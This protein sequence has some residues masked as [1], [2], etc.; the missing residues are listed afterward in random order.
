MELILAR[1]ADRVLDGVRLDQL[2]LGVQRPR[3][4]A[5]KGEAD[6]RLVEEELVG[7]R[8]APAARGRW[9]EGAGGRGG[10][11]AA[12]LGVRRLLV[13][14]H[15]RRDRPVRREAP[16]PQLEVRLARPGVELGVSRRR[17]S[18]SRR[19][20]LAANTVGRRCATTTI[21][22]CGGGRG[23]ISRGVGWR[24]R[25]ANTARRFGGRR[26]LGDD[27]ASVCQRRRYLLLLLLLLLH[28]RRK[29]GVIELLDPNVEVLRVRHLPELVHEFDEEL[30]PLAGDR[31]H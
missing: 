7:E 23:A 14:R 26:R 4:D 6:A 20:R 15:R 3:R 29:F 17:G 11:L 27:G 9:N 16:R 30:G 1:Q 13:L 22:T 18:R 25:R 21:T 28:E 5:A 12:T 2:P 19:R 8:H 10:A 24:T 31:P